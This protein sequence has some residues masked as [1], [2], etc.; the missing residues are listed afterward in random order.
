MFRVTKLKMLQCCE[1]VLTNLDIRNN[2]ELNT[3]YIYDMPSLERV[4]VSEMPFPP[5]G[6]LLNMTN[7]PNVY[8]TTDCD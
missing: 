6:L 7:S 2:T 8:F 5:Q 1:N 3:L 4:C